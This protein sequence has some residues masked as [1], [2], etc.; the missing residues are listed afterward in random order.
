MVL[1]QTLQLVRAATSRAA[2]PVPSQNAETILGLHTAIEQMGEQ[3]NRG[4][5]SAAGAAAT[6]RLMRSY[7]LR[8][9]HLSARY[10]VAA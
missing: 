8:I 3:I 2:M 4:T 1:R 9:E 5:L 7:E 10:E 6:R